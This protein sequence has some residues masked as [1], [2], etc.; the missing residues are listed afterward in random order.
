M[1]PLKINLCHIDATLWSVFHCLQSEL[2]AAIVRHLSMAS[3]L[4]ANVSYVR[5]RGGANQHLIAIA[6]LLSNGFE[7]CYAYCFYPVGFIYGLF[8]RMKN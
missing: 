3:Q 7:D 1:Q 2:A 8:L 4:T 6:S 5:H